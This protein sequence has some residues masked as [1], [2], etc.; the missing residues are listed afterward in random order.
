M[1]VNTQEQA[2]SGVGLDSLLSPGGASHPGQAGRRSPSEPSASRR[3]KQCGRASL[4]PSLTKRKDDRGS[5]RPGRHVYIGL[6]YL[7]RNAV[8]FLPF[9]HSGN[10]N[11]LTQLW[12]KCFL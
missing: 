7:P 3:I 1:N 11:I 8:H 2:M 4:H 9:R 5:G 6:L 12:D 10:C